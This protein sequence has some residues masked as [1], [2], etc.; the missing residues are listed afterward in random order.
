MADRVAPCS[1]CGE[2]CL[3]GGDDF[4]EFRH[5]EFDVERPCC[6]MQFAPTSDE[7]EFLHRRCT[8][9]FFDGMW[10]QFERMA[11]EHSNE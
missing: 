5:L 3:V 4:I 1:F 8:A 6:F 2:D 11:K 9:N 7:P 10:M